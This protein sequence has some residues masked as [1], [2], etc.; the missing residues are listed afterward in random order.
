M[1]PQRTGNALQRRASVHETS[2]TTA[3]VLAISGG[4]LATKHRP[5]AASDRAAVRADAHIGERRGRSTPAH[6]RRRLHHRR[7]SK[8]AP[9]LS[10]PPCADAFSAASL[11][12]AQTK[13]KPRLRSH[14]VCGPPPLTGPLPPPPFPRCQSL[15]MHA[16]NITTALA[17]TLNRIR[18][19]TAV[20]SMLAQSYGP[21]P[22]GMQLPGAGAPPFALTERDTASEARPPPS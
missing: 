6:P 15:R 11:A 21:L 19:D 1:P 16:A 5:A 18:T 13:V 22:P 7:H 20:R 4:G 14:H 17:P 9:T 12:P 8:G 2:P 3:A 10:R